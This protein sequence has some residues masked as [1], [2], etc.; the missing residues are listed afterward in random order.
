MTKAVYFSIGT[1]LGDRFANLQRALNLLQAHM[2]ITAISPVFATEPWGET[3]QPQFLNMC[4]AAVTDMRPHEVLE[5]VK[6]I[7]SEMGRAPTRHWGPR[8]I[9]IDLIFFNHEIVREP[10]LTVPHPLL[11]ERAFVLAPLANIIPDFVH[12]ET[13]KTVQE[14]LDDVD[15]SGVERL[16]E[17]PFPEV[18]HPTHMAV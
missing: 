18:A 11:A 4:A 3:D 10:D 2:N 1:N 17:L 16:V 13:G 12:P 15:Q 9:D 6:A 7:E 8:L 5:T 14:M